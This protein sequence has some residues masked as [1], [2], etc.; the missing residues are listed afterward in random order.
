MALNLRENYKISIQSI[1]SNKM[2][3]ILTMVIIVIGIFALIGSLIAIDAIKGSIN[4]SFT[5][6]GANTFSIRNREIAIRIGNNG[7]RPKRYKS[8]SY[9][10]AQKFKNDFN[11]PATVSVSTNASFAAKLTYESE[12]TNPNVQ[13]LGSDE[14]YILAQGYEI[15][16][17]RNFS[18]LEVTSGAPVAIIGKEIELALF[19]NGV[20]PIDKFIRIGGIKYKVL[21]VL[22]TKGTGMGFGGDKIVII[23]IQNARTYFSQPNAN[24]TISVMCSNPTIMELAIGEATGYFR[25]IRGVKLGEEPNFEIM[26]SDSFAK[27]LLEMLD[28]VSM[29]TIAIGFITLLGAAI[30]LMNIMFVGVKERTKEIGIRKALGATQKAIRMQF[31]IEAIIIC[32]IGGLV[33]ILLGIIGGNLISFSVGVGFYMPWKWVFTGFTI[34]V[35]TGLFA[36]YIPAKQASKLDPIESLRYE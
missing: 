9:E 33:G 13:V 3:T 30:G 15:E 12:K 6:M 17:G 24:F 34:C 25:L 26:K 31:L 19:K 36:G 8:I 22:K 10:E 7:K 35:F 18:P 32:L 28:G 11:F 16:K 14:N 23:P 27:I 21:S 29:A 4:T 2:R 20:K 1:M 5:S